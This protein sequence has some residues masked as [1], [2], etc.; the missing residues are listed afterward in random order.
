MTR[1]GSPSSPSCGSVHA[2]IPADTI[3]GAG[4]HP[5]AGGVRHVRP[6]AAVA[7]HAGRHDSRSRKLPRGPAAAERH[8]RDVGRGRAR[9]RRRLGEGIR[10]PERRRRACAP[11]RTR[12]ISSATSAAR[13]RRSCCCSASSSGGCGSTSRSSSYGLAAPEADATLRQILSHAPPEPATEPFVYSPERYA[14]LTPLMEWCAPQ[15]Y[16]K[17]VAHRILNRL[18]MKDSVPGTDLQDPAFQLPEGL[19][20]PEDLERYRHVLARLA[21]PYKVDGKGR[22]ERQRAARRADRR[23]RGPRLDRARPRAARRGARSR[24][25]CW[26][27]KRSRPRG[28]P[29]PSAA[30]SP[31]RWGSAGS[32]SGTRASGSCGTSATCRTAIRRSSSKCRRA[33]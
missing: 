33:A 12:R 18:A 17:S 21:V 29:R 28:A 14:Q 30:A 24:A 26:R 31:R 27:T 4:G 16:R 7:L 13:S 9:R 1:S 8:S 15:P 10:I 20:D 32:S 5:A 25:C 22:A 2:R 23:G 19:F 3:R 11:R 6:A